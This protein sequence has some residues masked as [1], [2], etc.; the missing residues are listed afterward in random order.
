MIPSPP[1]IL[2]PAH[3]KDY[4]TAEA[5]KDSFFSGKEFRTQKSGS[6]TAFK[7]LLT[8]TKV[9]LKFNNLQQS[10]TFTI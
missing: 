10:T 3:G 5:V 4:R 9:M 2:L 1:V 8:G 7:E 6:L